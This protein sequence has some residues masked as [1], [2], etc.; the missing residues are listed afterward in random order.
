[1][2]R[3][4]FAVTLLLASLTT[5]AQEGWK[6]EQGHP[7]PNTYLRQSQDGFGGWLI[8]TSDADWRAK[9]DTP[10]SSTP[11][12]KVVSTANRGVQLFVLTFFS[13]PKLNPIN[14]ADIS[15]DIVIIKP[16]GLVSMHQLDTVC[17]KGKINGNLNNLYLSAPVIG[18]V[19]DSADPTGKWQINITLK[20]NVRHVS[21]PLSTTFELK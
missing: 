9:W 14:S 5:F 16:D 13:N 21:L 19:G 10:S 11:N 20:D 4:T 12:F 15:C 7:V 2:K 1:M 6:D 17:F 18:F 3:F 8:V